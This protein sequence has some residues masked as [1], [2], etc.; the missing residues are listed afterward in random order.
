MAN[1]TVTTFNDVNYLYTMPGTCTHVLAQ[2]CTDEFK[3]MVRTK[4]SDE[5]DEHRDIIVQLGDL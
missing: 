2:D 1:S 3:F 5:K 4:N